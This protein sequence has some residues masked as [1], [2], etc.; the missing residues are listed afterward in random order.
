M[1]E[2]TADKTEGTAPL[3]V[4]FTCKAEVTNGTMWKYQWNFGDGTTEET[5]TNA[6]SATKE[7]TFATAGTYT[8]RVTARSTSQSVDSRTLVVT[9]NAVPTPTISGSPTPSPSASPSPT[10][11]AGGSGGGC[12]A[13]GGTLPALA[14]LVPAFFLFRRKG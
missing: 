10:E 12:N 5:V 11:G 13:G 2:F 8:V 14:L 1:T 7:H 9:V 6:L 3:K 4:T